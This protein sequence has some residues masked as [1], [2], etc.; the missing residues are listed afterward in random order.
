MAV[1]SGGVTFAGWV[2]TAVG[3]APFLPGPVLSSGDGVLGRGAGYHRLWAS[4]GNMLAVAK[5]MAINAQTNN[6]MTRAAGRAGILV[7]SGGRYG[8]VPQFRNRPLGTAPELADTLMFPGVTGQP[9]DVHGIATF[10]W[11]LGRDSLL[12]R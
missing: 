6:V 9:P 11:L 4:A 5:M 12:P 10:G 2:G 8:A 1:G 7:P 3:V